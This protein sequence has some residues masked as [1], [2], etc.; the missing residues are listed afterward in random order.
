MRNWLLSLFC[1]WAT[2][3]AA[4]DSTF[5]LGVHF[6]PQ[7]STVYLNGRARAGLLASVG[8]FGVTLDGQYGSPLVGHYYGILI[9]SWQRSGYRFRG[10]RGGL[11]YYPLNNGAYLGI[12]YFSD[13]DRKFILNREYVR[14]DGRRVTYERARFTRTREGLLGQIGYRLRANHGFYVDGSLGVGSMRR[15]HQYDQLENTTT[16]SEGLSGDGDGDLIDWRSTRRAGEWE[17]ILV[18]NATIRVG[19]F[20]W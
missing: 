1:C 14:E 11:R 17:S 19:I 18:M 13:R 5:T 15:T 4:Q 20:L 7:E 6:V 9:D 16:F 3:A 2:V 12:E 10:V 8:R